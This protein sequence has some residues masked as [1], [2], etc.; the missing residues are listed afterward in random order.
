M[1]E[2]NETNKARK[3][4]SPA[5]LPPIERYAPEFADVQVGKRPPYVRGYVRIREQER[6]ID[7][8]N[9]SLGKWNVT[10]QNEQIAQMQGLIGDA[11]LAL[12]QAR[13]IGQELYAQDPHM[14]VGKAKPQ[15]AG[16]AQKVKLIEGD[17]FYLK[18]TFARGLATTFGEAAYGRMMAQEVTA[19][20]VSV[21]LK[22]PLAGDLPLQVP[23]QHVTL[24]KP[25]DRRIKG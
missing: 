11:L 2:N 17:Q 4:S 13:E 25:T 10:A 9:R 14:D 12:T 8:L 7:E 21:M 18:I 24:E 1:T 15:S 19:D 22:H 3:S 20:T 23:R 5:H 6:K 16:S